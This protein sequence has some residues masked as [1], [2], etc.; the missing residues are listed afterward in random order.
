MS[1][2]MLV[3]VLA[4]AQKVDVSDYTIRIDGQ[5]YEGY[6][7]E[8]P[9]SLDEVNSSLMKYLKTF[10]KVKSVS[11]DLIIKGNSMAYVSEPQF[12]GA[13]S[14]TPL[15]GKAYTSG[16]KVLIWMGEKNST[17]DSTKSN[18]RE[19]KKLVYDFGVKFHRDK[20]QVDINEAS[21]AQLAAQ[22]Q[23]ARLLTEA[24]N[25]NARLEF[26]QKEKLR[27][28]K[29]L[30][31]NKTEYDNLLLSLANNK[32]SQDSLAIATEQIKKMVDKHKDRQQK[33]N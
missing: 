31:D 32:K 7:V 27:L 24:K 21:Q 29:A 14:S 11:G 15:Y 4:N 20:V 17:N 8:L 28:E 19:L 2:L 1:I 16:D 5:K 30:A 22:K 26:N 23:T 6:K 33:I 25:L 10:G 12:G 9:G 3:V 13:K 18:H